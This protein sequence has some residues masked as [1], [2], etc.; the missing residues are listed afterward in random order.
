MIPADCSAGIFHSFCRTKFAVFVAVRMPSADWWLFAWH[1]SFF[2]MSWFSSGG[3]FKPPRLHNVS[4]VNSLYF[5]C[6]LVAWNVMCCHLWYCACFRVHTDN[7]RRPRT[8][9][10]DRP[11]TLTPRKDQ[12][13]TPRNDRPWKLTATNN[14]PQS[15][16]N[17]HYD[18]KI[19][20][21]LTTYNKAS[22]RPVY[23]L[24]VNNFI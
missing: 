8:P 6:T 5:K 2:R 15:S 22:L 19:S 11:R 9:R 4:K 10:N 1:A 21:S 16:D 3:I 13:V 12:T 20:Q 7:N 17:S 23:F 24:A 14:R 18:S